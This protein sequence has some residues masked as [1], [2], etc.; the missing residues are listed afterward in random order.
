MAEL[1]NCRRCNRIFSYFVGQQICPQCQKEENT[2][3]E[4]VSVYVRDHPG[5]PLAM[6]AKEMDTSYEKLLKFVKE[7]RLQIKDQDGK[8]IYFCEHC[9]EEVLNGKLCK[10]CESALSNDLENSKQSLMS[11]IKNAPSDQQAKNAAGG[12]R[13]LK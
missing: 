8:T 2:L 13:F 10:S 11:K 5:V 7:G 1:R 6:V 4:E 12:F 9:G 3:F